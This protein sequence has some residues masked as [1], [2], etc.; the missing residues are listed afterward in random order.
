VF[1]IFTDPIH[2]RLPEADLAHENRPG[3]KCE[4]ERIL[5]EDA[6]TEYPRDVYRRNESDERPEEI[7]LGEDIDVCPILISFGSP[8]D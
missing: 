2:Q 6:F 1:S 3:G 7:G 8:H 5:P 4:G